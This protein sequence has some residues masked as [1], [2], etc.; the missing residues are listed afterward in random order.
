MVI[1]LAV[2]RDS[3][4]GQGGQDRLVSIE[5]VV[6]GPGSDTIRGDAAA[7]RLVGR[8][9]NDDISGMN[10][11]DSI[12][13]G[14]GRDVLRGEAGQDNIAGGAGNDTFTIFAADV[15]DG[16]I[17]TLLNFE[18]ACRPYASTGTDIPASKASMAA[19]T[20][21]TSSIMLGPSG[22]SSWSRRT[23]QP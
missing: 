18:G 4:D 1:D 3:Q 13:G 2:A 14:E 7:N 6:G 23:G 5:T 17:D 8:A 11:N 15:A 22:V 21:T 10:G 20:F 19:G 9:G 16:T 12:N